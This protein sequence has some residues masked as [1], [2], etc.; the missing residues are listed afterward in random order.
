MNHW[1][2]F[3]I[4]L[5]LCFTGKRG[6][7]LE[8]RLHHDMHVLNRNINLQREQQ[9]LKKIRQAQQKLQEMG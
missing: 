9:M 7:S 5:I 1:Q 4:N 6:V 2:F 3:G 8:N